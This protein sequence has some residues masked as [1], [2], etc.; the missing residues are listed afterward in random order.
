MGEPASST[1]TPIHVI[2]LFRI[3]MAEK[4]FMDGFSLSSFF[5]KKERKLKKKKIITNI[6][7]VAGWDAPLFFHSQLET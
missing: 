2:F 4:D 6:K 7:S 3:T 5:P 1:P